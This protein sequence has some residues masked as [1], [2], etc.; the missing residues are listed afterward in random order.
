MLYFP[1]SQVNELFIPDGMAVTHRAGNHSDFRTS[2]CSPA[3]LS[4]GQH[5]LPPARGICKGSAKA[6][7]SQAPLV[8]W[9]VVVVRWFFFAPL[10]H[11]C[12][13]FQQRKPFTPYL[14]EV[15][16]YKHPSEWWHKLQALSWKK[17]IEEKSRG[18]TSWLCLGSAHLV[19]TETRTCGWGGLTW[20]ADSAPPCGSASGSAQPHRGQ[21]RWVLVRTTFSLTHSW[22]T[23]CPTSL[24]SLCLSS[25]APQS[26][27]SRADW[28]VE[29]KGRDEERD[30]G[31]SLR[32]GCHVAFISFVTT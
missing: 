8:L 26:Q 1:K 4:G 22:P 3:I 7:C 2:R 16:K 6:A 28:R 31:P 25:P 11:Q 32:N 19:G 13:R 18:L 5:V 23:L 12:L 9:V 14:G 17:R 20:P 10:N 30:R 15:W 29:I 24:S 21:T 27:A